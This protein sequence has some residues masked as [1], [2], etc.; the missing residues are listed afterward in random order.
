[1]IRCSDVHAL[2][3][4]LLHNSIGL[5]VEKNTICPRYQ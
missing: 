5:A 3:E 4:Q 2:I 1:M